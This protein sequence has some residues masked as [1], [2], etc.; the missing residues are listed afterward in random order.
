L[1]YQVTGVCKNRN[2]DRYQTPFIDVAL[3]M[4]SLTA[5]ERASI[6]EERLRIVEARAD[7]S[8]ADLVD[9]TEALWNVEQTAVANALDADAPLGEGQ[10]IKV[11]I[12]QRYEAK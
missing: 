10:R 5:T 4:R 6:D 8:V 12:A 7:E 3:S 11:P 1:I 2:Y 9:R